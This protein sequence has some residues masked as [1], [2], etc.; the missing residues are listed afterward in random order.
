MAGAMRAHAGIIP[1]AQVEASSNDGNV[2]ENTIDGNLNTRWSARGD[3][4]WI[5][6]DLGGCHALGWL[7]ID[8]Y[9]GDTRVAF[10][11]VE[12]SLDGVSWE[13]V[14]SGQSSGSTREFEYV[15][16]APRNACMVRIVGHGNSSPNPET[17]LWNSITE[18]EITND[19]NDIERSLPIFSVFASSDDGNV[20]QNV[21]DGNLNTRWSAQ[22]EQWIEIHLEGEEETNGLSI[23]WHQGDLRSAKF[24]IEIWNPE[25]G[26]VTVFE[27]YSSGTT[28]ELEPYGFAYFLTRAVRIIGHGNSVN[29][30]NSITEVVV[31]TGD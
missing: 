11:D 10:Y 13:L 21:L 17:A 5:V 6:Y 15:Y 8:W 14:F 7:Y 9:Q 22:G 16:L 30:W 19:V 26:W 18:V 12:I 28:R 29:D 20:P 25:V 2:P 27:G 24:D 23:A 3:G 1:I 4:Q 31:T